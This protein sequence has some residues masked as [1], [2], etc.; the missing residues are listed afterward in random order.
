MNTSAPDYTPDKGERAIR[1]ERLRDQGLSWT[2]INERVGYTGDSASSA[3]NLL[4]RAGLR[5]VEEVR[6]PNPC[7]SASPRAIE[8]A[9]KQLKEGKRYA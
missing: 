6:E 8:R 4:K 5:A 3:Q 7:F 1:I 2:E 9:L